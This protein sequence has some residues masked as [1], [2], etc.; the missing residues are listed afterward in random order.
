MSFELSTI[1]GPRP[2]PEPSLVTAKFWAGCSEEKL[3][4]MRCQQCGAEFFPP[5]SFCIRCQSS[6]VDWIESR[7]F[8]IVYSYTL[9]AHPP[10]PG[11]PIP[12]VVAIVSL[13]EGFDMITNIVNCREDQLRVGMPVRCVFLHRPERQTLPMFE[14]S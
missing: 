6:R 12:T 7:G 13:D 11:F 1:D 14:P 3:L 4:F 5:E 2:E 10:F 9:L 8:G